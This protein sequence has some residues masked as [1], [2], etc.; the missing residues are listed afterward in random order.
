MPRGSS[1]GAA[2]A[3]ARPVVAGGVRRHCLYRYLARS[4]FD[5]GSGEQCAQ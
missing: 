2:M 5:P 3:V 1:G 4:L